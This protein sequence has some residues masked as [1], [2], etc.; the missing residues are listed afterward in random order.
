MGAKLISN[1]YYSDYLNATKEEDINNLYR[2]SSIYHNIF[3]GGFTVCSTIYINELFGVISKG[4][5]NKKKSKSLKKK[6]KNGPIM[7]SE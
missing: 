3:L 6:L 5:K 7:I 4:I 1:S 2:N